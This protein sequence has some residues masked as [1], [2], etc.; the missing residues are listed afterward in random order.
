[1]DTCVKTSDICIPQ[2]DT[3]QVVIDFIDSDGVP[4]DVASATEIT[5]TISRSVRVAAVVTKKKSDGSIA[6]T[7]NTQARIDLSSLETGSTIPTGRNYY[8]CRIA[9]PSGEFA[10]VLSGAFN[11]QDTLIGDTP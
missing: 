11:I 10:T 9:S 5:F 8:E 3:R 2:H 6:I 4:F 7:S 1:M